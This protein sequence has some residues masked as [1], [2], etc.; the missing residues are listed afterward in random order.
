MTKTKAVKMIKHLEKINQNWCFDKYGKVWTLQTL[1]L[2]L[3]RKG[4]CR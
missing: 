2:F 1:S 4:V 3:L